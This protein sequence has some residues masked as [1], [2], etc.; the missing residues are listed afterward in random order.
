M[1]RVLCVLRAQLHRVPRPLRVRRVRRVLRG[2]LCVQH[3]PHSLLTQLHHVPLL[4]R[5]HRVPHVLHGSHD[6]HGPQPPQLQS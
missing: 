1:L 6:H 2:L 4:L 3:G 5:A